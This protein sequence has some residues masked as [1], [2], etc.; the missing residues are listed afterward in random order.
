MQWLYSSL[1]SS[2]GADFA[3]DASAIADLGAFGW[4]ATPSPQA[5]LRIVGL[6]T[7]YWTALNPLVF[8]TSSPAA[9][10]GD[11]QL[12]WLNATRANASAAGE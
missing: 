12:Q 4:Y 6:N 8:N 5:G 1:V 11:R 9:L 7:N 10:L 2:F 3:G